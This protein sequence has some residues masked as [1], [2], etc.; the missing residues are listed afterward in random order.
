MR[1]DPE[2]VFLSETILT[3]S[4]LDKVHRRCNFHGVVC[5]DAIGRSGGLAPMWKEEIQVHLKSF[6]KYHIDTEVTNQ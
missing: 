5:V 2:V 3:A 1:E 4:K 6:S